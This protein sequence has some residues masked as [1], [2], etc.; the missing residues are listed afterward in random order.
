MRFL[1]FLLLFVS[2]SYSHLTVQFWDVVHPQEILF[3]S[4]SVGDRVMKVEPRTP[5]GIY[6]DV[7]KLEKQTAY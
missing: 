1:F 7:N 2:S 6:L 5:S 4:I 3:K